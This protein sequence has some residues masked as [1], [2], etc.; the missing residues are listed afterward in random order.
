M[1]FMQIMPNMRSELRSCYGLGADP[2]Y[3]HDN[4]IAGTAY[5]RELHDRYGERGL[6]TAFYAAPSRYEDHLSADQPLPP[7]T[8]S[9]MAAVASLISARV[10]DGGSVT[11][12]LAPP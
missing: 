5:L 7:E 8:L 4:I 12:S 6:L 9:Y 1:G 3:A 2:Y 10:N 11:A